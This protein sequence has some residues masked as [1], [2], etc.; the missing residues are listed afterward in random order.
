MTLRK[1]RLRKIQATNLG[2]HYAPRNNLLLLY[3]TNPGHFKNNSPAVYLG[4][5]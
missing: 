5:E 1:K 3:P 2:S 4:S